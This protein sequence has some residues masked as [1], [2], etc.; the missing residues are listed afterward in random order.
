MTMWIAMNEETKYTCVGTG[1]TEQEA[2]F[3]AWTAYRDRLQ[4]TWTRAEFD[5]GL[6]AME[7]ASGQ[8]FL[9]W[10]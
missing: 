2:R 4:G 9:L 7:I 10:V 5:D 3:N 8:D 6:N 1:E